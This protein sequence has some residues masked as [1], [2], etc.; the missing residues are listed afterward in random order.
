MGFIPYR[1]LH[2][3]RH[4]PSPASCKQTGR[5]CIGGRSSVRTSFLLV[6]ARWGVACWVLVIY[7]CAVGGAAAAPGGGSSPST[8]PG[9]ELITPPTLGCASAGGTTPGA[10]SLGTGATPGAGTSLA[11]PTVSDIATANAPAPPTTSVGKFIQNPSVGGAVSVAANNPGTLLGLSELGAAA[12]SGSPTSPTQSGA[13]QMPPTTPA[14]APTAPT[15][16]ITSSFS[17]FQPL[18]DDWTRSQEW[19]VRSKFANLGLTGSPMELSSLERATS[20]A[21]DRGTM[22]AQTMSQLGI[23]DPQMFGNLLNSNLQTADQINQALLGG[24]M[25]A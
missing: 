3:H 23:S 8:G 25:A 7:R 20:T 22:I 13:G 21:Q 11:Q 2:Q 5:R 24:K 1:I 9:S 4:Q 16:P 10:S 6:P 12:S 14:T 19:G 18:I 15:A 17:Q